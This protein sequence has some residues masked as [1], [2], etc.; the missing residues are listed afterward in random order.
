MQKTCAFWKHGL[1]FENTQSQL[2]YFCKSDINQL[3]FTIG[4]GYTC[5]FVLT[6]MQTEEF[7]YMALIPYVATNRLVVD[8]QGEKQVT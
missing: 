7:E 2:T 3:T 5:G 1:T 6:C 4:S 8:V